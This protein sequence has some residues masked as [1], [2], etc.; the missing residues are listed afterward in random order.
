MS[1]NDKK[2]VTVKIDAE[3]QDELHLDL[4]FRRTGIWEI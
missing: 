3:L 2:G 1:T 4:I